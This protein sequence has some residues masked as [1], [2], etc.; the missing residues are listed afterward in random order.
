MQVEAKQSLRESFGQ[1]QS[2]LSHRARRAGPDRK[3][4]HDSRQQEGRLPR[5]TPWRVSVFLEIAREK[6]RLCLAI[7][8]KFGTSEL[9][10]TSTPERQPF[11]SACSFTPARSTRWARCMKGR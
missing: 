8:P 2:K 3:I 9:L 11:P 5:K 6:E 4:G 7:C 10:L 1:R